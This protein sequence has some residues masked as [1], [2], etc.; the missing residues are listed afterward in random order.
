MKKLITLLI[1]LLSISGYS[2]KNLDS[3][4]IFNYYDTIVHYTENNE[5]RTSLNKY[6]KDIKL[7]IKGEDVKYLKEEIKIIVND[8]NNLIEPINITITEDSTDYNLLVYLGNRKGF[9]GIN[10]DIKGVHCLGYGII[11]CGYKNSIILSE[12][13]VDI[14]KVKTPIRQKHIL[15]EEI[16]QCLGLINDTYQY[17]NSI[18]YEGYSEVTQYSDLDKEIIKLL[19]N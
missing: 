1:V 19:Y 16:T 18:F 2:Q 3:L 13:F 17:D 10:N 5:N 8:L 12:C 7:Y 9:E 11:Y 14:K 15:R 4:T 6:E